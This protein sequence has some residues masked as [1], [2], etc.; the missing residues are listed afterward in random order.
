MRERLEEIE[1]VMKNERSSFFVTF[2]LFPRKFI[3]IQII[4]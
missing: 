1:H 2:V 3:L 4:D